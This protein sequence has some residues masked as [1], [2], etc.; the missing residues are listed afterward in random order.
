MISLHFENVG[1]LLSFYMVPFLLV[2][3]FFLFSNLFYS[4]LISQPQFPSVLCLCVNCVPFL[5]FSLVGKI[6]Y[7]LYACCLLLTTVS[8][9]SGHKIEG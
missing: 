3:L 1:V 9:V 2:I 7:R 6:A 5:T 4:R 8:F